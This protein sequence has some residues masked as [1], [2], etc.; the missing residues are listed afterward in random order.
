MLQIVRHQRSTRSRWDP[1]RGLSS[2]S[3]TYQVVTTAGLNSLRRHSQEQRI[4]PAYRHRAEEAVVDERWTGAD[5][6]A[7]MDRICQALDEDD[8][9]EM[10]RRLAAG[11]SVAAAGRAMGLT[12]DRA[13]E[14]GTR[15]RALLMGMREGG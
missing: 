6:G 8:E 5:Y 14:L 15:V 3:Y 9:R 13:L 12:E 1:A 4:Q 10:A 2:A 7:A 11:H